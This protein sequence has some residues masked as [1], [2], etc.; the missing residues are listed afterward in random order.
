MPVNRK[1]QI[2]AKVESSQGVDAAPGAPDAILVFEP[3]LSDDVE[4][5][6]RV[7]AGPSLSRDF[8]PIGRKTRTISFKSDF[9]GSGDTS[10]P[11]TNPDWASLLFACGF[12]TGSL[13]AVVLGAVTG[14]GFMLGELVTQSSG[15]VR[16]VIVGIIQNTTS[17]QLHRTTAT[18]D[19]LVVAELTGTFTAAATVGTGSLSTSTASAVAAYPGVAMQPTSLNT[20]TVTVPSWTGTPPVVG[21]VLEV[22]FPAGITIGSCQVVADNGSMLS[23]EMSLLDGAM[24]ATYTLKTVGGATATI[25]TAVQSKTPSLSIRHNLDGRRRSLLGARGDFGLEAEVGQPLQFSWTFSGD[26]G[27]AIDTPQV[28][29]SGLSTIKPP[30]FVGAIAAYGFGSTQK[31]LATKRVSIQFGNQVSPNLDA[32]REGGSTG[33]YV[34]DRDPTITVTVDAVHGA[35][36]WE[37]LRDASTPVRCAF[38]LGSTAGNVVAL[39]ASYCQVYDAVLGE[40]NGIS[41]IEVTLKPR[42]NNESGDDEVFFCQL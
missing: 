33:S 29:T 39:V 2:L 17:V 9:R 5:I 3:A 7:P 25:A 26:P 38:V 24:L 41:T 14:V 10:I 30:R 37:A 18:S 28:A 20:V 1:Q 32:N 4:K 22:Q 31:R 23:M 15:A 21:E 40:D 34:T 16:G 11:I 27:T 42:R 8:V 6:D 19:I 12:T 35:F 36:D 13:R